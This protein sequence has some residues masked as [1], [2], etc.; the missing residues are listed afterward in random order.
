[1]TRAEYKKQWKLRNKDKVKVSN[2]KWRED[3]REYYLQSLKDLHKKNSKDPNYIEKRKLNN[4]K[5]NEENPHYGREAQAL[6]RARVKQAALPGFKKEVL[7][8][9]KNC[10]KGY[11]VDHIMPLNGNSMSGLHV[12]W[13]L[14]YLTAEENLRKSNK[15]EYIKT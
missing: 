14:Q 3:N 5:F 9:Y 8:F 6:R 1:M 12:P 2:K 15:L 7:E 4:R 13:N 10:P 11:H